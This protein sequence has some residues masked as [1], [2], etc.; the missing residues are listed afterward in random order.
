MNIVLE[1][2][3]NEQCKN[4]FA[5]IPPFT[6]KSVPTTNGKSIEKS[7]LFLNRVSNLLQNGKPLEIT[8]DVKH[9]THSSGLHSSVLTGRRWYNGKCQFKIR[10]SW[11]KSCASYNSLVNCEKETGSFWVNDEQFV[12]GTRATSY[13]E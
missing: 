13:I 2:I 3:A 6:V 11:G 10:N 5:S 1:K 4:K 12:K 8:Y 7:K 9:Y